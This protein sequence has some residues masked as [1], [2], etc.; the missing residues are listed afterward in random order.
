MLVKRLNLSF[1]LNREKDRRA[2][3][4]LSNQQYK[5]SYVINCIL[6][7]EGEKGEEVQKSIIK[8]ALI[9]VLSDYNVKITKRQ[10]VEMNMDLLPDKIFD[11]FS[12][13]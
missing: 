9:E 8:Q 7:Y 6:C 4:I 1:D 12:Q 5:T 13:L 10:N 3:E 11:V 2:Y